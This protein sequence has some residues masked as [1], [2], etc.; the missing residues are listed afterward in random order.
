[1]NAE[2]VL[3]MVSTD[4]H[5]LNPPYTANENDTYKYII[6]FIDNKSRYI[7]HLEFLKEKTAMNTALALK[8]CINKTPNC[9]F[10]I[11]HCDNGTE[12][13]GEF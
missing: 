9:R 5:Y 2:F 10:A 7:I 12:F 11:L 3:T 13:K 4:L 6:A 1:M 8:R